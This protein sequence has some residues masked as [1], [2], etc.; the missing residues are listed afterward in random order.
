[1]RS[2]LLIGDTSVVRICSSRLTSES[3]FLSMLLWA[4]QSSAVIKSSLDVTGYAPWIP[5]CVRVESPHTLI[6]VDPV[7]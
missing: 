5:N 1:M 3:G 2:V 4:E 7:K 6:S